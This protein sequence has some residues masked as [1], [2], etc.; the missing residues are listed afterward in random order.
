MAWSTPPTWASNILPSADMNTYVRD[1]TNYLKSQAQVLPINTSQYPNPGTDWTPEKVGAGLGANLAAKTYWLVL[2]MLQINDIIVS[3]K[4]V[5]DMHEEGGD[6]CTLDAKMYSVNK[7]DPL[8]TT[9]IVGG[10][11]TQVTADGNFDVETTLTAPETIVTDKQYGIEV[12]G[13]CSNVSANEKI[14]VM[15]AEVTITRVN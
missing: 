14:E 12:T 7:A 6:T 10:G 5:G 3:Y 2:D 4:M 8:T 15:G 1:N 9:D 13:T 11:M